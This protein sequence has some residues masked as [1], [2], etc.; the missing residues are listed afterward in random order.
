MV[1][2]PSDAALRARMM[3]TAC[4]ISSARCGSR[5]C[6]SATEKTRLT[7]RETRVA[8]ASSE[9]CRAYFCN[10]ARSSFIISLEYG[11]QNEKVTGFFSEKGCSSKRRPPNDE[12]C[13]RKWRQE[14]DNL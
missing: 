3:N 6:L 8:N 13:S 4:V 2:G 5:T 14:R 1:F 12:Q 9:L 11:R 10:K 7:W